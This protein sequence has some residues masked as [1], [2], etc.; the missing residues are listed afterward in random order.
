MLYENH[1]FWTK[2]LWSKLLS[3]PK[4]GNGFFHST[5]KVASMS[6]QP[7]TWDVTCE[8]LQSQVF[9]MNLLHS[10]MQI[11]LFCFGTKCEHGGLFMKRPSFTSASARSLCLR[12]AVILE[13]FIPSTFYQ[14]WIY[15]Y[16]CFPGLEFAYTQAPQVMQGLIMGLFLMTSG[17]GSYLASAIV[18]I[19]QLWRTSG[20][21]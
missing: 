21:S 12:L 10:V 20:G 18:A 7:K 14:T 19:V 8:E 5:V 4:A 17:L 9:D 16:L 13:N 11:F 1:P 6:C 3:N 2:V 15:T